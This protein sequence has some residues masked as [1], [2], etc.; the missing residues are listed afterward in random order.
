MFVFLY[1][2]WLTLLVLPD[3][4]SSGI[5]SGPSQSQGFM[6]V[7]I[8]YSQPV[9]N[10]SAAGFY[11]NQQTNSWISRE[12]IVCP[13][14]TKISLISKTGF[15]WKSLPTEVILKS[16]DLVFVSFHLLK[17]LVLFKCAHK[18]PQSCLSWEVVSA[19]S[20]KQTNNP[21][22][23]KSAFRHIEKGGKIKVHGYQLSHF[24]RC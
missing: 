6:L 13:L 1:F 12:K 21:A 19:L 17:V 5:L 24:F 16:Q 4:G 11:K 8:W 22:K 3:L 9:N 20:H 10:F 23:M 15:F 7:I 14:M 18:L 2:D